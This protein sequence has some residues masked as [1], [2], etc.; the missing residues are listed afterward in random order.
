MQSR[1]SIPT[2]RSG[3]EE[4]G[5]QHIAR[6]QSR[7]HQASVSRPHNSPMALRRQML[8]G[9]LVKYMK[10]IQKLDDGYALRFRRSNDLEHLIGIIA[11]YIVFESL[12]SPQLTFEIVQG[13]RGNAFWLQ[14]RGLNPDQDDATSASIF[15]DSALSS[16]A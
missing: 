14:V 1:R 10:E 4:F 11:D 8:V 6:S 3:G 15:S 2:V 12:N 7:G 5:C 16:R 9:N 13:P